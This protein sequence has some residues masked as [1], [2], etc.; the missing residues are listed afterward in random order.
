MFTE[1]D[2]SRFSVP[3]YSSVYEIR[4]RKNE[5]RDCYRTRRKMIEPSVKAAMDK[6]ICSLFLQSATYRFASTLLI[7]A[8]K[9]E[10]IDVMPIAVRALHDKKRVAFPRCIPNTHDM[11][12][13]YVSSVDELV[14]GA[15][16]LLEPPE[17]LPVYQRTS[18]EAAVCVIP[19]L[20]YD[21]KRYRLG[22]GKGY[23]D[24]YLSTFNGTKVGVIYS[25]FIVDTLPHGRFDLTTDFLVT[26]RGIRI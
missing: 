4:K 25:D 26:E 20:V 2:S 16:H 23:Y 1:S 7:F 19:A 22:Y 17:T 12:F 5:I 6:K 18:V 3:L 15:Y 13:H 10:E 21:R 24:R 9:A 11:C 8:P 14:L